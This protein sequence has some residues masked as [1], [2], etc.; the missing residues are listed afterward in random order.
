MR[1]WI[2]ISQIKK[3]NPNITKNMIYELS[4]IPF[5]YKRNMELYDTIIEDLKKIPEIQI[6]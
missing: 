3:I 6:L 1:K 4:L 5:K 2:I